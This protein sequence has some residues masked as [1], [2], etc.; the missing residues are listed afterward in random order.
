MRCEKG[1]S[2]DEV[3]EEEKKKK[4]GED[5]SCDQDLECFCNF[6]ALLFSSFIFL[7]SSFYRLLV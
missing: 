5:D 6:P 7:V 1:L 2:G 3:K 4:E